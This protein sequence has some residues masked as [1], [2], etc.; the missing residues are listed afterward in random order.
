MLIARHGWLLSLAAIWTLLTSCATGTRET[1]LSLIAR[2]PDEFN[3]GDRLFVE[4]FAVRPR[5]SVTFLCSEL[6]TESPPSARGSCLQVEGVPLTDAGRDR[7]E[8][9]VWWD[10][11]ER[12]LDCIVV[13]RMPLDADQERVVLSCVPRGSRT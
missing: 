2:E 12:S 3:V 5:G 8:A 10:P 7:H 6:G 4:G 13:R 11:Q 9:G 1:P